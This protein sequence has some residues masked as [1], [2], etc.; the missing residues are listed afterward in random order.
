MAQ[1]LATEFVAD[2]YRRE[3]SGIA[4][5]VARI[6]G[7][8][9][10][11]D[12]VH[13]AFVAYLT[14]APW[15]DKPGAWV[16][17]VARN[18]ALNTLRRP[19]LVPLS[20]EE[21]TADHETPD[22][23]REAVR[24]VIET[25]LSAIHPRSLT[26]L[27]MK[28]FEGADYP[29]IADAL[30]V[31]VSQAHVIVHRSLRRLGRELIRQMAD[32][33]GAREC[34][35]ALT[36]LAGLTTDAESRHAVGADDG[37][38]EGPCPLC[39]PAWDEIQALRIGGWI[40]PLIVFKDQLKSIAGK[41]AGRITV[42]GSLASESVS[43]ATTAF[44]AMGVAAASLAP[45]AAT[46]PS[47]SQR[48]SARIEAPSAGTIVTDAP[49]GSSTASES[50]SGPAAKPRRATESSA[51]TTSVGSAGRV[52][53]P[54]DDEPGHVG[55]DDAGMLV[56]LDVTQPCTPPPPGRRDS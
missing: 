35:P 49:P 5:S 51:E 48:P 10:A 4:R 30:G 27:R 39:A 28:F 33:H 3:R 50:A 29:A 31:R 21:P 34:A 45:A 22:S 17:T 52:T 38:D 14:K 1:D 41:I 13:D 2:L 19:K 42:Q 53:P 56:C 9:H 44:V 54:K 43:R 40:A 8:S 7:E 36:K 47:E 18:R 37:H 25:A 16:S 11:E 15:A 6:A 55:N 23:E 24:R 20:G 26:A 46:I 32:A 12:L